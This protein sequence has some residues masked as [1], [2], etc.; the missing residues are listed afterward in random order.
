MADYDSMVQW[1]AL[2]DPG[3]TPTYRRLSD[4]YTLVTV[5]MLAAIYGRPIQH[6]AQD[7]IHHQ[8]RLSLFMDEG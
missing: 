7:V 4:Y 2:N 8:L 5:Q 3:A 6:V 1:I